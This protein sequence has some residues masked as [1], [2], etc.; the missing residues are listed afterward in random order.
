MKIMAIDPGETTGICYARLRTDGILEYHPFQVTDDVDDLWRRI[1][2]FA[3]DQIIIEDF[4][5]RGGARAGLNL[6]PVQHIGVVRLYDLTVGKGNLRIQKA[7][8]G[9]SYYNDKSLRNLGLYV[10]GIPHGMDASRHLL[11]W[12]TFG[13]GF[14]HNNGEQK[15]CELVT[16]MQAFNEPILMKIRMEKH[17]ATS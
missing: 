2:A 6:K 5:F 3:P 13:P 10:R 14:K 9:K 16:T 17:A 11:Q 8:Q 1:H 7:A 15:F 12:F 4:E